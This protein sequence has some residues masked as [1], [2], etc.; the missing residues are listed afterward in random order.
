MGKNLIKQI[1]IMLVCCPYLLNGQ[2]KDVFFLSQDTLSI[3]NQF[4]IKTKGSVSSSVSG[5]G[6]R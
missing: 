1:I 3:N 4:V 6:F 2:S 5:L